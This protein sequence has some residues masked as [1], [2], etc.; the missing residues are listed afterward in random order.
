M[1]IYTCI[2][3]IYTVHIYEHTCRYMYILMYV[4]LDFSDFSQKEQK[5]EKK[6]H[7]LYKPAAHP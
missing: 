1:Y 3:T 4:G 2:Y 5:H 7:E 6:H